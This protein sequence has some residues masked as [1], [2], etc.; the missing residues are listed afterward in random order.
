MLVLEQ[1]FD[2]GFVDHAW[3]GCWCCCV[4]L[5]HLFCFFFLGCVRECIDWRLLFSH[6]G[7]LICRI[8][9][10]QMD[11]WC[12][13]SVFSFVQGVHFCDLMISF[14]CSLIWYLNFSVTCMVREVSIF[15]FNMA[16]W[17][18]KSCLCEYLCLFLSGWITAITDI[19]VVGNV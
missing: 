8:R 14:V 15:P 16:F 2:C 5:F 7:T 10:V 18:R 17:D 4:H 6:F 13:F 12:E 3:L 11:W 1:R 9:L 19:V